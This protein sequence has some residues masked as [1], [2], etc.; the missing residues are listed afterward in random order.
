MRLLSC[1]LA[2]GFRESPSA[3]TLGRERG[4][5][6]WRASWPRARA[7]TTALQDLISSLLLQF[8]WASWRCGLLS[9]R[10]RSLWVRA[11]RLAQERRQRALAS[12]RRHLKQERT[13]KAG[14]R[15]KAP[16]W[17]GALPTKG[18]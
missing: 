12:S 13:R 3:E 4:Y 6:C 18:T 2:D 17:A 14:T 1:T 15:E 10:R 8:L 5:I 7:E 16:E 11:A 9:A